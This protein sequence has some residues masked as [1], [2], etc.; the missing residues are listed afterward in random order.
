MYWIQAKPIVFHKKVTPK[1]LDLF[2][3]FPES[4]DTYESVK[5]WNK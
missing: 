5:C 2:S 3:G 1:H 4:A